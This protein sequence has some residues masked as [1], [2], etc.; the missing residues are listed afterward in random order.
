M[1]KKIITLLSL[2]AAG[3]LA[4]RLYLWWKQAQ[5]EEQLAAID[6]QQ[7]RIKAAS[8]GVAQA[9][10]ASQEALATLDQQKAALETQRQ[11]SAALSA[12]VADAKSWSEL[13]ALM[14]S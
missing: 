9:S 14:G 12:K 3:I 2:V 10:Q 8:A 13:N 6:Q 1:T 4:Y 5:L 7:T 11:K